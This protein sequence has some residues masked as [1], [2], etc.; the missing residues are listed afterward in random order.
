MAMMDAL[1]AMAKANIPEL[2]KRL[3]FTLMMLA[4]YRLG[5]FVSTP[6][7]NVAALRDRLFNGENADGTIFGMIN[8]S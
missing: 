8:M 2:K 5:V 4:I 6:G 3:W 7:V 1:G